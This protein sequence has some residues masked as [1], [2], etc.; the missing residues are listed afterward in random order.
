M[1][2]QTALSGIFQLI[3][4]FIAVVASS[5][6]AYIS[7]SM[8]RMHELYVALFVVFMSTLSGIL[9]A[10]SRTSIEF[11]IFSIV[12][13]FGNLLNPMMKTQITRNIAKSD[14][15]AYCF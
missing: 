14:L 8:M 9:T 4:F 1:I 12:G 10:L 15:G 5:A 6:G 2:L 7:T 3:D 11:Y 13:C